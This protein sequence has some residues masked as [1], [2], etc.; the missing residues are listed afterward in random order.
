MLSRSFIYLKILFPDMLTVMGA[1]GWDTDVAFGGHRPA[2]H[3]GS[4]GGS[5]AE[6]P[7]QGWAR[8]PAGKREPCLPCLVGR[9]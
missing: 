7:R 6:L 1:R 2:H 8:R 9:A 5:R 4:L 3:T